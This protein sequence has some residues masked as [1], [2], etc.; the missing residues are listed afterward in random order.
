MK[1][2]FVSLIGRTNAGK[3]SLVNYL[4]GEDISMVSHKINATRRKINA[5]V[6]NGEDQIIF[7]DT[8]GLH[9]SQKTM[10][11]LM[12]E[13]AIKSMGDC[14]LILFLASIHD[15]I[16]NYEKFLNLNRN[17]PHILVLSKIDEVSNEKVFKKLQQYQRFQNEFLSLIPVSIKS[18]T[19]K[20]PLLNE[21]CKYLPEHEYYF[22]PEFISSSSERE[23]IRDFILEAIFECVSSEIPYDSDVLILN[24]KEKDD[25]VEI[26]ADI[27]TDTKSHKVILVGKNG[28]T[29]KR[30][31][32][33]SRKRVQ[34][35]LNKRV[36]LKLNVVIKKSWNTKND[37]LLKEIL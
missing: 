30:I 5:I 17:A 33:K 22:D 3:S 34:N 8:P 27:I 2:G 14:D 28:E 21:I 31:G 6:M 32:I 11:K 9:E 36:F 20:A 35:F 18:Q 4:L 24:M 23:I 26:Y 7:I 19:Y 29:I 10:N 1:S 12:V 25:I 15:S 37:Y 13:S 16:E